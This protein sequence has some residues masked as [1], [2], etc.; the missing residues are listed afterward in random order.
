LPLK[1]VVATARSRLRI[2]ARLTRCRSLCLEF[3]GTW[4]VP[5]K[6]F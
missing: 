6:L 3:V 1:S 2:C 4:P 5:Q